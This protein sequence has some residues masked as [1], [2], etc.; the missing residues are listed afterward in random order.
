MNIKTI[1]EL[2]WDAK[3]GT[4]THEI[5]NI[6]FDDLT[7][8]HSQLINSKEYV[9]TKGDKLYFL[10]GCSIPRFKVKLFCE[11]H[12]VA[13]VKYKEKADKIFFGKDTLK[14]LF[15]SLSGYQY[16]KEEVLNYLKTKENI[17]D[18]LVNIIE[19]STANIISIAYHLNN[20]LDIESDMNDDSF[21][22]IND[23]DTLK[24]LQQ[25]NVYSDI[26]IVN[27]L[28]TGTIMTQQ[29]YD[30]IKALIESDDT[31][32]LVLAM[33]TMANFDYQESAVYLLLLFHEFG[34]VFYFNKFKNHINFK[35]LIKY[36]DIKNL[37]N[38]TLNDIID[39]LIKRKLMNKKNLDMLMPN[40][41]ENLKE[42]AKLEHFKIKEIDIT[43]E[44]NEALQNNILDR[45]KN[46]ILVESE[47]EE[48]N[49]QDF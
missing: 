4:I 40:I 48:L 34:K 7:T 25:S 5:H 27:K 46:T 39:S 14:D 18:E 13:L 22:E 45:N 21:Y 31:T 43:D 29:D 32:N 11:T 19:S 24:Y 12:K 47:D 6:V 33:E 16:N 28:N 41:H 49:L 35:S 3:T 30:N 23:L 9:P 44:L 42:S 36:F 2:D 26:Q 10:P 8:L 37:S 38:F 20:K 1:V 17:S 15:S